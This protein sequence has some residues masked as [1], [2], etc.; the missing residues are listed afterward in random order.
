[1]AKGD[2]LHR[3]SKTPVATLSLTGGPVFKSCF[4]VF[5]TT[6]HYD[7]H[8]CHHKTSARTFSDVDSVVPVKLC[9]QASVC[10]G[11]CSNSCGG[12]RRPG[13]RAQSCKQG[14]RADTAKM[15]IPLWGQIG[16]TGRERTCELAWCVS[17]PTVSAA[18]GCLLWGGT[19]STEMTS[20]SSLTN[21]LKVLLRWHSLL[22]SPDRSQSFYQGCKLWSWLIH[23]RGCFVNTCGKVNSSVS[24]SLV[25][26][27]DERQCGCWTMSHRCH[28]ILLL[29]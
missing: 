20:G 13:Q 8:T 29:L 3:C 6:P 26:L 11:C 5:S 22:H 14:Q 4:S 1:M 28:H 24:L 15:W 9:K 25:L 12:D 17:F 21:C 18:G 10:S 7:T 16:V 23:L 27:T 2:L 19:P